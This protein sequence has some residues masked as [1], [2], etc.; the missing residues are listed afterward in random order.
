MSR[1]SIRITS[2]AIKPLRRISSPLRKGV[3]DGMKQLGNGFSDAMYYIARDWMRGTEIVLPE[4]AVATGVEE[5]GGRRLN[6][7]ALAGH[8]AS[9]L[10]IYEE[11]SRLLITG[12]LDV[13]GSRANHAARRS[14]CLEHNSRAA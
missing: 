13:P 5:I 3:I 2:S 12:D 6:L 1:I 11:K 4:K 14:C 10:A 7:F 8:T 9:D